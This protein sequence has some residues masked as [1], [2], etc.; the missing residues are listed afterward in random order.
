MY[1]SFLCP[2]PWGPQP[3]VHLSY[4]HV[5][6]SFTILQIQDTYTVYKVLYDIQLKQETSQ[7][8][9]SEV[10]YRTG[11]V[12]QGSRFPASLTSGQLSVLT[13]HVQLGG[14]T[15]TKVSVQKRSIKPNAV[16]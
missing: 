8:F 11:C 4:I 13:H 1:L 7:L 2:V 5:F 12:G 3:N 16:S 6:F 10:K 14:K 9:Q 15:E